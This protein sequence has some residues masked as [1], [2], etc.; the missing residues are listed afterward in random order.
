MKVNFNDEDHDSVVIA[1]EVGYQALADLATLYKEINSELL[2]QL[3][4]FE[5]KSVKEVKKDI[6]ISLSLNNR[7]K[8][9]LSKIN[10]SQEVIKRY[11][12]SKKE[13][14]A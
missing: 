14:N 4:I 11:N 3:A 5:G 8:E 9:C 10:A 13:K 12:K 2:K 7:E 1:M 6:N